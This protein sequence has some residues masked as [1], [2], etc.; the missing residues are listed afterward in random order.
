MMSNTTMSPAI[1]E[2]QQA[3]AQFIAVVQ[4]MATAKEEA[5][6][7]LKLPVCC[8][9]DG[10]EIARLHWMGDSR[11]TFELECSAFCYSVDDA[12]TLRDFLCEHIGPPTEQQEA[13]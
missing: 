13:P 10:R 2:A 12:A 4:Q 8:G 6:T 9:A 1:Q 11:E 5:R 3:A 7:R